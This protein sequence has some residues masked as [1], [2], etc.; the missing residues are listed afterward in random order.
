MTY[1][2]DVNF[3]WLTVE[4]TVMCEQTAPSQ[5]NLGFWKVVG[6]TW[7]LPGKES[8]PHNVYSVLRKNKYFS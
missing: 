3:S 8:H 6:E 2:F 5:F 7:M 4:Q 1:M